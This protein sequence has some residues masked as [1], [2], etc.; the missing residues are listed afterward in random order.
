M[1]LILYKPKLEDLWFRQMMLED[2][3]TMSFNAHWGGAIP[4]PKEDWKEWYD[5]WIVNTE[6]NRYYRYVKD[7]GNFVGEIAYHFDKTYNGYVANVIIYAKYRNKGYGTEAL[8][9]LCEAVKN[10]GAHELYDDIAIDNPAISIFLKAG[11][12]EQYRTNEIILLKKEL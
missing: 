4:F 5:H 7:N 9:M 12:K 10:S 8:R 11:F 1:K 2:D 3:E 6:N